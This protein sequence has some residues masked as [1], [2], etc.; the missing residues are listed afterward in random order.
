MTSRIHYRLADDANNGHALWSGALTVEH[1]LSRAQARQVVAKHLGL[2]SLPAR[3]LVLSDHDLATGTWTAA[4]ASIS[5]RSAF[6]T[7]TNQQQH[8]QLLIREPQ[9]HRIV[10]HLL[11]ELK[12]QDVI[13]RS[14]E[15][16]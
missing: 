2:K 8:Q 7:W 5:T 1:R 12:I 9:H 10:H 4:G 3:T 16:S 11:A 15:T 6:E 13:L 14:H